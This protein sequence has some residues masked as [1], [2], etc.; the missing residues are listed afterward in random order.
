LKKKIDDKA[1]WT[2]NQAQSEMKEIQ[3]HQDIVDGDVKVFLTFTSLNLV[4]L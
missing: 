3:L 1:D 4:L 2:N